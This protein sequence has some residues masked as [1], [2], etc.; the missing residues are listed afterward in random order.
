MT[1]AAATAPPAPPFG[2][3]LCAMITPFDEDGALDLDG[4]QRLA[5]RPV[6]RG[7]GGLVL[8]GATGES[9]TTPDA[10]KTALIEAVRE[11]VGAGA[12]VVAGVGTFD[13]RH[14]VELA[15]EAERAGADGLLV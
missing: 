7:G 2:R 1:T 8:S 13:T 5:A 11:A 6:A 14:T 3:A 9:P 12:P 4:A 15:R 10:E